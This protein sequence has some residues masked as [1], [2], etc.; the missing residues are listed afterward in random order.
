M[1]IEERESGFGSKKN[2]N[3]FSFWRW[4]QNWT[5]SLF[6]VIEKDVERKGERVRVREKERYW[7]REELSHPLFLIYPTLNFELWSDLWLWNLLFL[8]S[9]RRMRE[10][11]NK[12]G[13]GEKDGELSSE[14]VSNNERVRVNLEQK[15]MLERNV[16]W[17]RSIKDL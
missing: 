9:K 13:D 3:K 16:K 17:E 6:H 10:R 11:E 1:K 14:K 15:S 5:E 8:F 7:E 2:C 4:N 12:N